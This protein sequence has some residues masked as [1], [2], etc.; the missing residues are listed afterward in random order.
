MAFISELTGRPVTDY[1]GTRIGVLKDLI[2]RIY[3]EF[4][5]PVV[6]A[7]IVHGE[8]GDVT[9]PYSDLAALL[10]A[11]I[12]LRR[13]LADIPSYGSREND[14]RLV[15]DVLNKQILATAAA[16]NA[17]GYGVG[18]LQVQSG[19]QAAPAIRPFAG[20]LASELFAVGLLAAAFMRDVSRPAN[21]KHMFNSKHPA[22]RQPC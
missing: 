3:N 14:I 11:A 21:G 20:E 4:S 18:G 2:A 15:E 19:K 1:D 6:D 13:P 7:R 5:H 10:S 17:H 22:R 16:L 12:P 8:K 9:L